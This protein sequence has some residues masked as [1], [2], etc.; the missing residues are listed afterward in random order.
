M[1]LA[2]SCA[3]CGRDKTVRKSCIIFNDESDRLICVSTHTPR[4]L[5]FLYLEKVAVESDLPCS[6]LDENRTQGFG[7]IRVKG[8]DLAVYLVV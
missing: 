4:V 6:H 1:N 8:I 7:D 3:I 2:A 5:C